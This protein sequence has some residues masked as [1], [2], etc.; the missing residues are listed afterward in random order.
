[1]REDIRTLYES[2]L[3]YVEVA[4]KLGISKSTVNYHCS[5]IS[6]FKVKITEESITKIREL[7]RAGV[8]KSDIAKELGVSISTISTYVKE[9]SIAP[10]P[11]NNK[12]Y[13]AKN[14]AKEYAKK[15]KK[16][17]VD[18][19]GGCCSICGYNKSLAALEFHH[20]N[21]L[22]KDFEISR[23]VK[24]F[25]KLKPELDKCILVCSNCHR[26]IHEEKG[27]C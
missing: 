19:K 27:I 18:Y 13:Y 21:P 5:D 4:E 9:T 1:M 6:R 26:E 25:S 23:N 17:C 16:Q 10:K 2:G 3:T 8:G 11:F 14:R 15:V 12:E 24:S 7:N 20:L 22:I